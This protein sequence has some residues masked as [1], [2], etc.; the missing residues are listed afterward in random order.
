MQ[1]ENYCEPLR[2]VKRLD[3][4]EWLTTECIRNNQIFNSEDQQFLQTPEKSCE[5]QWRMKGGQSQSA[6]F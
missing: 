3:Q 5:S 4:K 6:Y 2:S 1:K